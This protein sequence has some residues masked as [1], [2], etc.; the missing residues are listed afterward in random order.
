[1]PHA[2]CCAKSLQSRRILCECRECSPPGSSAHG[3]LQA[4]ILEWVA[5]SFPRGSFRPGDWTPLFHWQAGSLPLAPPGIPGTVRPNN[6]T[7]KEQGPGPTDGDPGG[8]PLPLGHRGRDGGEVHRCLKA[9][10]DQWVTLV[11]ALE[12]CRMA[13]QPLR[14]EARCTGRNAGGRGRRGE[15]QNPSLTRL[16]STPPPTFG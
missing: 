3:M 1:M 12:P 6:S 7:P 9:S 13:A 4:R 5:T 16:R 11:R 2:L 14:P 8:L 10:A 15:G